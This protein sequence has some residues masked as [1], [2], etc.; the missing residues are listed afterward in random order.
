MI[1]QVDA[2]LGQGLY[3]LPEA[4]LFS[5]T[6]TQTLARWLFG[7]KRGEAVVVP[8]YGDPDEKLVSF[9]DFVEALAVRN[10]R[11]HHKHVP[12]SSIRAAHQEAV[13]RYGV[14][15]PFARKHTTFLIGDSKR[16]VIRL[17]DD[18]YRE[19]TGTGR[20]SK[21]ITKVVEIYLNDLS[22]DAN[23]LATEYCAWP[24]HGVKVKSKIV[25]N[26]KREF[27]EPVVVRCGYTAETLWDAY[28]TEGGTENA[29][30]ALGVSREDIELACSYYDH[31]FGPLSAS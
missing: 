26:P 7:D 30:R 16:L 2:F 17:N 6:R 10:V 22:F 3:T 5:R 28:K 12:L 1:V 14:E 21:L 20:G 29:A 4:A 27:G 24:P 25:M 9:L 31:L 13:S 11:L 8:Q 18:D 23:S 19:L 15:H